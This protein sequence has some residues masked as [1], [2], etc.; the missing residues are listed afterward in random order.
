M[1]EQD[2]KDLGFEKVNVSEEDSGDNA[3]YYYLYCIAG[4]QLMS[5][6][7]D[8]VKNS[9]WAIQLFDYDHININKR[10]DLLAL[11][12]I[13]ETNYKSPKT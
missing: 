6:S 2:L 7:D 3:Y 12:N 13:F 5:D 10:K 8:N 11:I 4:L 1:T 9:D